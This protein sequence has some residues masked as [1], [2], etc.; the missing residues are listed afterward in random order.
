MPIIDLFD[1]SV[2]TP[3]TP[4]TSSGV[5][6]AEPLQAPQQQAADSLPFCI[7]FCSGTG[8]LT[9]Q[10]R[11]Q[12]LNQ[13][14]G[15][16]H[17]VKA[18]AK[19]PVIKL[20]MTD[21]HSEA[22]A[23]QWLRSPLCK[24]AH[25]GIP[26][27]TSS[28][29]REIP[30]EGGPPPLR[31]AEFPEGIPGVKPLDQYK[32]DQANKVYA[33]ACRL[34]LLCIMCKVAWSLEQ[35]SRSWFWETKFW[36]WILQHVTPI[37]VTFQNCMFGGQRAKKTTL[38]TDIPGMQA[39][40]KM[41]DNK[42]QHLPWGKT[43]N[44]FA[45][46]DEVEYPP[47]LCK[48]WAEIVVEHVM[49]HCTC[50]PS[51][52]PRNPDKSARAQTGKQTKKSLAFMPEWSTVN[53]CQ[54][55]TSQA[56]EV[57]TK[58]RTAAPPL[59]A[60][61]RILRVT[62][63]VK[64]GGQQNDG[65]VEV[66]YGEPWT[67]ENFL[68]E[69]F[70]RGH[71]ANIFEGLSED[72]R[73]AIRR[74][75]EKDHHSLAMDR[76][77]WFKRWTDRA[78]QLREEEHALHL[79]LPDNRRKILQG[80]R[81]L[82]LKEILADL[83]Y[84]DQEVVDLMI[85]GFDLVGEAGG[86]GLLPKDFVPA[87]LNLSDLELQAEKSNAMIVHSTKSSGCPEVDD[88]LWKKTEEE[89]EKG[90]LK[91]LACDPKDGGRFSR[92]FG[93]NQGG[94][95]RPIDNYSE[96]Q[97]NSAVNIH[98]K[99]T[100]DGVDSI[101]AAAAASYIKQASRA[102]KPA[103]LVGR[104]FDLKSAYRQLA[105]SDNSLKWA[106]L[107]AYDPG[108]K[109]TVLFQQYTLPFGA[110]ASVVAFLRCARMLQWL[111]LK[112]HVIVTCYFDDFVVL[113]PPLLAKSAETA[114]ANL[115]TLLG[116]TYDQDGD[117]ADAISSSISALGVTVNLDKSGE[118]I[119]EVRNTEKRKDDIT[120]RIADTLNQGRL[121]QSEAA[122]LKGRLGFAEG[123]LFGRATKR[124]IHELGAHCLKTP[125]GGILRDA[126][127]DALKKVSHRL[128]NAAPRVVDANTDQVWFMFTDACFAS[129]AKE[130]GIG[131]V[132]FDVHGTVV[133][134]FKATAD[135]AFCK[136][137]MAE[138]QS[139]AIGELE[140]FAVLVGLRLWGTRLRAK[141]MVAFVDNEGARYL[142]LKGHSGNVV[143]DYIVHSIAIEE[144]KWNILPWYSRVPSE[145]NIADDPSRDVENDML[146]PS[147]REEPPDLR[148]LL[149]EASSQTSLHKDGGEG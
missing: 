39:L 42:H 35:P 30:L 123:Q 1:E 84:P 58:L 100:V 43:N 96:S 86:G 104:S 136:S 116:W 16:D 90:W 133:S 97:I 85:G 107:A 68:A 22:Q 118:G 124:L 128:D 76:A 95:V 27:G 49:S 44:G 23:G 121:S 65:I 75:V 80:K 37:Y 51:P 145:A 103:T 139:Q 88:S 24:Y 126:T 8:G 125:K 102:G 113:S 55:P 21:P 61:A 31:S 77:S 63:I 130:G 79:S 108:S 74:N 12:G 62:P 5:K 94:K 140:A 142:I 72:L 122:S 131:G 67:T 28:R 10:L 135:Q 110:R 144:E 138:S 81:F 46:A 82:V 50:S 40:A 47:S 60:Y 3:H 54:I 4:N 147:L 78:F 111:A 143:L 34:I 15:V 87:T 56:P 57:G 70:R 36:K 115:L 120:A 11:K 2:E 119:V 89:E 7:E 93:I 92:R 13:S 9:A 127:I 52:L 33:C 32:L 98:S 66:A 59:P 83:Q 25:F 146:P 71:P 109:R 29:A 129:E 14:F 64:E 134:W 148:S 149:A 105:V 38:A 69:A 114:F 19:A 141:H 137:F 53:T 106:R 48:Q 73:R 101:A 132:L 117:K 20:D 17:V 18:T 6:N 91:R 26:C 41:C 45:T 112:L 99:C